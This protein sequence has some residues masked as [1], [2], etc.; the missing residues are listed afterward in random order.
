MRL[1]PTLK[2]KAAARARVAG[3]TPVYTIEFLVVVTILLIAAAVI[4]RVV[5]EV[6]HRRE[7]GASER[8]K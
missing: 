1:A 2:T 3:F 7:S 8:Q 5:K 6:R 4:L